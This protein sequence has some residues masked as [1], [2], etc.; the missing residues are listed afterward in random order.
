[1]KKE[2][3]KWIDILKDTKERLKYGTLTKVK[4]REESIKKGTSLQE[5]FP[6]SPSRETTA[7]PAPTSEPWKKSDR[8]ESEELRKSGGKD[9]SKDVKDFLRQAKEGTSMDIE[10]LQKM[11]K[12]EL[13]A[14][15]KKLDWELERKL[16][17]IRSRYL[18]EKLR[19]IE[20]LLEKETALIM[21]KAGVQRKG[22]LAE[23]AKRGVIVERK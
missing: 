21:E 20:I 2:Q 5:L 1:M 22:L 15:D 6:A 18:P 13:K 19:I 23:L 11:P 10:E 4:K 16:R 14:M 8:P 12:S 9:P 7:A 17:E 3:K